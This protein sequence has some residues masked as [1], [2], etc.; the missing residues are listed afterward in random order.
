MKQSMTV[1]YN[2]R[3]KEE[4][5][6][7]SSAVNRKEYKFKQMKFTIKKGVYLFFFTVIAIHFSCNQS[8]DLVLLGPSHHLQMHGEEYIGPR[9]QKDIDAYSLCC[10]F[11][12]EGQIPL[13]RVIYGEDYV[14]YIGIPIDKQPDML[15]QSL[16][17]N[18]NDSLQIVSEAEG[19]WKLEKRNSNYCLNLF[20]VT[21]NE[22]DHFMVAFKSDSE[23]TCNLH[24][25]K[26]W[27]TERIVKN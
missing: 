4:C 21:L 23:K 24:S 10:N 15:A 1:I 3:H 14:Y 20:L 19:Y 8:S 13:Y 11:L 7:F 12:P 18:S 17:Q 5:L 6:S 2:E 16:V 9:D 26:D 25:N 27:L 22:E